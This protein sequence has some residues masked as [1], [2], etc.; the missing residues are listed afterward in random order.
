MTDIEP[1]PRRIEDDPH[2]LEVYG[3]RVINVSY[4]GG[5][6]VVT[7]NGLLA[8]LLRRFVQEE[9]TLLLRPRF[10]PVSRSK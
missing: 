2:V 6:V 1:K 4:D 9:G 3:N 10:A 7:I 8:L 5:G